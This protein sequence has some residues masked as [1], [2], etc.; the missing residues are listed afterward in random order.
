MT[1]SFELS[2]PVQLVNLADGKKITLDI[3]ATEEECNALAKRMEIIA[4]KSLRANLQ[5]RQTHIKENYRIEGR[6]QAKL[7][8]SCGVTSQPV[9]E[10]IDDDF[11]ETLTTSAANLMPEDEPTDDNDVPV[12]LIKGDSFDAGEIVVQWLTLLLNP[13][14]RSSDTPD[15]EYN[16]TARTAEGEPTHTPFDVL[17][18]L[19]GE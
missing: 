8:Q 17:G 14:P 5:I 2:R 10:A 15:Y 9:D 18:K 7:V 11:T 4:L 6:I 16:E 12:D 3:Q 1:T 19:K 13:Y